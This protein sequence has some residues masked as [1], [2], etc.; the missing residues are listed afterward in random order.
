LS[1]EYGPGFGCTNLFNTIRFAVALP[2]NRIVHALSEQ[3][4]WTHLRQIICFE[5]PTQREFCTQGL[6]AAGPLD[7]VHDLHERSFFQRALDL[8]AHAVLAEIEEPGRHHAPAGPGL[9]NDCEISLAGEGLSSG[10]ATAFRIWRH[11]VP[12]RQGGSLG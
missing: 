12:P 3:L 6:A 5:D 1:E 9:A 11:S 7:V 8:D 2:D 4:S 10:V